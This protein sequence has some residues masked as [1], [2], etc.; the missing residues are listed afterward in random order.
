MGLLSILNAEGQVY[1]S[2]QITKYLPLEELQSTL[3]EAVHEKTGAR[4]MHIA[5]NDPENLFCLSFQTL[6]SSSNGIAHILEHTVLCG[7]KKFPIK[8]PFFS[9]TRRSLNTYMNALTGQDFTCYP[10]SSQV[11]KDFY[12]LLEVYLDAVFHPEL[13]KM[14]FLQ[15]GHRLEWTDP[16]NQK[17][18]LH[19]QGVV[20]NEM[21]GA[22]SSPESRL[23]ESV[24]QHLTPDLPYRFNSGGNPKEIPNLT[25][26]E[27]KEFH[28]TF[29]HPSRCIFFFYGNLPLSKHLDFL[30]SLGLD[31]YEKVAPLPPLPLQKRFVS[32]VL[33]AKSFFPCEKS[34]SLEKKGWIVFSFL[35]A[36][37]INQRD[38]LAL[39][40]LESLL[41][42][43]DASPLKR[44]LLESKLC[45]SAESSIDI[46]MSEA[47][48][49]IICKGCNE[50]DAQPLTDLLFKTLQTST[51]SKDQIEASL[52]QLEFERMEIGAEGIPFG[53]TLFFRSGLIKQH[54]SESENALLI[55]TL[56][57]DLRAHLSNP[58][59]LPNI[60]K[61]YLVDNPH[62]VRLS[63]LPD[64]TLEEKERKEEEEKLSY[65]SH[66]ISKK[67]LS[68]L[69]IELKKYQ[70]S[71]ENQ[72][73]ECL[74]QVTLSD[75]PKETKD[76]PL[77]ES[78]LGQ[79]NILHHKCFTNDIFYVDLIY[80][81][82]DMES[83]DLPLVSLYC[84]TMTELGCADRNYMQNLEYQ[85][86]Y[87]GGINASLS[88]HVSKHNPDI[89]HPSFSLR[90]KSLARNSDKL[91]SLF[92]DVIGGVHLDDK[93]RIQELLLQHTTELQ[94]KLTKNA[95]NFAIQT[96][97]SSLSPVSYI[98]N[99]WNG[100]AYYQAVLGFAKN[101]KL[102]SEE[103]I[104][105]QNLVLG[106]GSPHLVIS[107]EENLFK[108][109]QKNNFF[110]LDQKLPKRPITP[111]KNSLPLS[112]EESQARFISSTVAFTARGQRT[113]A[114]QDPRSA[115]LLLATELLDNCYLHK[116][117][118]EKGGAYGS[119]A[120]YSPHTGNFHFYSFRDPQLSSTIDAF[121]KSLEKIGKGLFSEKELEEAK[122]GVI[123][124][125]DAPVP[126]GNRAMT[127][128]AWKRS[129]RTYQERQQ[130]RQEILKASKED[131]AKAV[132][133]LLLP[134]PGLI[135]SFLGENLFKKEEKKLKTQL[136]VIPVVT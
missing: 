82:P 19:F 122:F 99:Q 106:R 12:N 48:F 68:D 73:L 88:L 5:N 79:L 125:I 6:P 113:I 38:I 43:T 127:A 86:A 107:C 123:Q 10:A 70:E 75:V 52:H 23:W 119:G 101:E 57:R 1:Q 120:S 92:A 33:D 2:F 83:R 31:S 44:A 94:N 7:S 76:F 42:D 132:Q 118:R 34:Q 4:I 115:F 103:L 16:K 36:P 30:L 80:D 95:L 89:C 108:T 13:K 90:G 130:F 112:K 102:L 121:Q 97:L 40:L 116:E 28:Q 60:Q 114:Y 64:P 14:S 45:Q 74:P 21:K 104:R 27:L 129:G 3:I 135:V 51:F 126:P 49:S 32:P 54:G 67:E 56:F 81:L 63:F 66:E 128:Y 29:Y 20:Y 58:E 110:G 85:Q 15:E 17:S 111:W 50:E 39:C 100:L 35:T 37:L 78:T 41:M 47:P 53:L 131:V 72:S 133:D 46:E 124:T 25:Y 93:A 84:K 109:L 117:I 9:M 69:A 77:E 24:M 62:Y 91:L 8:D 105:I 11:E 18:P 22:L 134:N 59:F 61:K 136:L 26:E 98:H 71:I 55:H 87:T 65:M 96:S